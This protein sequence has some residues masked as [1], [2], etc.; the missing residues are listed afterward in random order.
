M[1]KFVLKNPV[2]TVNGVDLSDH[3]NQ[4]TFESTYDEVDATCFTQ[5]HRDRLQG[6]GDASMTLGFA[7]DF[8]ASEVDA[9][10]WPLS[11]SG[12]SFTVSA[13]AT[14]ASTSATN[15]L[16][17]MTGILLDYT[18]LDGGVGDLAQTSITIPGTGGAGITRA[19][20]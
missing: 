5:T 17:S 16:F 2:I 7:Q 18:P 1:A 8:A 13:K 14:N 12:A 4:V 11:Q 19:T 3:V 9:T 15:P 6:I 10:L 20:S